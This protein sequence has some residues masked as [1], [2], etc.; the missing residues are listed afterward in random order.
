M[1]HKA[2]KTGVESSTGKRIN[3]VDIMIVLLFI[4]CIAG[5]V[6]RF[7]LMD[8]IEHRASDKTATVSFVIEGV[9]SSSVDFITVGD[10]M[11]MIDGESLVG[12]ISGVE[13]ATPS[14]VYYHT[15]DGKVLSY[16]SV[17][18]KVNISG[19]MTVKGSLSERG[20]LLDG[21]TYIAP[22]MNLWVKSQKI[23]VNMLITNIEVIETNM[24]VT[25]N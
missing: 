7:G 16:S 2:K 23:S 20:F 3:A 8:K 6:L 18:G 24:E 14:T 5:M 13:P 15:D 22:N 9:S 4:V 12:E 11:Y 25:E 1:E 19:K 17:D 10:K 21:T